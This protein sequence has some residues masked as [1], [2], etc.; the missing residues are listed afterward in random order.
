MRPA[1]VRF[2]KQPD[3]CW[4]RGGNAL[5]RGDVVLWSCVPR[6]RN[7]AAA[8]LALTAPAGR[9]AL[10]RQNEAERHMCIH[11]ARAR[12][13]AI[14]EARTRR[15]CEYEAQGCEYEA[16]HFFIRAT[17]EESTPTHSRDAGGLRAPAPLLQMGG[18]NASLC[19]SAH[20]SIA[21]APASCSGMAGLA[22]PKRRGFSRIHFFTTQAHA[23]PH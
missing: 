20:C 18:L 4:H 15:G 16:H 17:G 23:T 5:I 10:V 2:G 22:L 11:A 1:V 21:T 12:L 13:V 6:K 8:V 19:S 3:G 9:R 14:R 7:G